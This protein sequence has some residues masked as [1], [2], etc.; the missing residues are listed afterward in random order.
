MNSWF[1]IHKNL[2]GRFNFVL[3]TEDNHVLLRSELYESKSSA[4][5][6]I[7]SVRSNCADDTH[8]E[9]K[10]SADHK[11]YFNLKAANHRIIGTSKM[12]ATTQ[13]REDD[14]AVVKTNGVTSTIR[15]VS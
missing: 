7:A 12:Y 5:N 9:R 14:I 13:S 6:G 10:E 1:E 15:E 11:W 8:Y 2:G 3:K 4:Q